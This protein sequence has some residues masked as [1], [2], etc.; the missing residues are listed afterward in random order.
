[1]VV[2]DRDSTHKITS[3]FA[4]VLVGEL[5]LNDVID[6]AGDD[7]SRLLC[8]IGVIAA[9]DNDR[10]RAISNFVKYRLGLYFS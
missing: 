7:E 10:E 3:L 4:V 8:I 2:V 9:S 6:D 5:T 1:M